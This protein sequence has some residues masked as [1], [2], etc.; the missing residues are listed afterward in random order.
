MQ[1]RR[2]PREIQTI[3]ATALK[4]LR[5]QIQQIGRHHFGPG[6]TGVDM[7]MAT[8]LIAAVSEVHLQRG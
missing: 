7:A 5:N 8:A 2:S 6:R 1:L 4:H 3:D